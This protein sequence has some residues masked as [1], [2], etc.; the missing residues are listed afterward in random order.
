MVQKKPSYLMENSEEALRLELKT[1]PEAV[2]NQADWCGVKPGMHVLDA[3]CGPGK[4]TSILHEMLKPDGTILGVDYSEE[5]IRYAK[6]H[7]GD[8]SGI[9]FR[10]HD[11]RNPLE[12]MGPFDL[13]WVRFVLEYNRV[14]SSEIVRDLGAVLKPGGSLCLLDLDYNC[15]THFPLPTDMERILLEL[16]KLLETRF[17]FDAYAGRKLYSYLYDLGYRDIDLH[18]VPH[19]LFYGKV[20]TED[21]FNWVKKVEVVSLKAEELF[22]VYPGGRKGFFEDFKSFFL[23]PRRFT[24]TPLILC[25][26]RKPS[27]P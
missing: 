6:K 11:L 21:V 25:K 20:R 2:R 26:G 10:F 13:I 22:V 8:R 24:Y 16:M 4:V 27:L 1:D 14:E 17:N 12:A 7:Y 19:H 9:E 18:L 5:M 23:S 15:L 3:G